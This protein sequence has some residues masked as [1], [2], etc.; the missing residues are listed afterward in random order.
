[1]FIITSLCLYLLLVV[2]PLWAK[3]S[4]VE[5]YP[6]GAKITGVI[7]VKDFPY[8]FT[9]PG[10]ANPETL[11]FKTNSQTA[12][13]NFSYK[14]SP[15]PPPLIAF[16]EQKTGWFATKTKGTGNSNSSKRD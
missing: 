5:L 13:Y 1:M 8:T 9:L 16:W 14:S 3:V 12:I 10:T 6:R 4:Q 2:Q 15:T 7:Q 11:T